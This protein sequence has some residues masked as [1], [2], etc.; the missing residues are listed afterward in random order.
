[1]REDWIL[2]ANEPCCVIYG[3]TEGAFDVQICKFNPEENM[4]NV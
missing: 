1:L 4:K 3:K 2:A